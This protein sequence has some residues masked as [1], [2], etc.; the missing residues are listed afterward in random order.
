MRPA[1]GLARRT[2]A[3]RLGSAAPSHQPPHPS[4]QRG[5]QACT[6]ERPRGPGR[7]PPGSTSCP[8]WW[9]YRSIPTPKTSRGDAVG[10]LGKTAFSERQTDFSAR[11][12]RAPLGAHEAPTQDPRPEMVPW[13]PRPPRGWDADV[14]VRAPPAH[15][16]GS[17]GGTVALALVAAAFPAVLPCNQGY[18]Q[19]RLAG[20]RRRALPPLAR[21]RVGAGSPGRSCSAS[22]ARLGPVQPGPFSGCQFTTLLF[23][24]SRFDP[25][26]LCGVGANH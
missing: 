17:A 5:S 7:P 16:P 24:G 10:S 11:D 26:Y 25:Y 9:L 15:G 6:L 2:P 3:S 23:P 8:T 1:P 21:G 20:W 13:A 12:S 19:T 4:S 18:Y 14:R 22:G